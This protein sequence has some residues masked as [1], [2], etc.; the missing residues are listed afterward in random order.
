MSIDFVLNLDA[1]LGGAADMSRALGKVD[2]AI[3]HTD[4]LFRR[5]EHNARHE[6]H[7]IGDWFSELGTEATKSFTGM[8]AADAVWDSLKEGAH[9]IEE[10]VG[11]MINAGA[12]AQRTEMAFSNMLGPEEGEV[13]IGNL[14]RFSRASEFLPKAL[15]PMAMQLTDAGFSGEQLGL[16]LSAV[17]DIAA[18]SPNKM[19]GAANA[20]SGLSRAMLTGTLDARTLRMMRLSPRAVFKQMAD[21][22]GLGVK[23][24]QKRLEQGKV[25][26]DDV[27]NSLFKAIAAKGS[28]VLGKTGAEMA[29]SFAAKWEKFKAIPEQLFE[30]TSKSP[31]LTTLGDSLDRV[32]KMFAPDTDLG[33]GI[34]KGLSGALNAFADAMTRIDPEKLSNTLIR[35]FEKL[36]GLISNTITVVEKLVSGI[37]FIY[38][39]TL[40]GQIIKDKYFTSHTG[41]DRDLSRKIGQNVLDQPREGGGPPLLPPAQQMSG[42]GYIRGQLFGE[43]VVKGAKEGLDAHSPSREF[44]E[45]GRMSA[46][47]YQQGLEMPPPSLAARTFLGG[48][49]APE[50]GGGRGPVSVTAPITVNVGGSQASPAEIAE[51]VRAE[52]SRGILAALEEMGLAGGTV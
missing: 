30:G 11:E 49:S 20:V 16:A 21:D 12:E 3:E 13:L 35:L 25:K 51:A 7:H 33:K 24:V 1:K 6:L 19:E 15:K 4:G 29:D 14:E 28:G 52:A 36:P 22:L 27:V 39:H 45:L 2:H 31:G 47:G 9:F 23:E 40:P 37:A 46:K 42:E 43:G 48:V 44:E 18:R 50:A 38:E 32:T 5:L 34:V 8:L 17:S 10:I 41:M 26:I